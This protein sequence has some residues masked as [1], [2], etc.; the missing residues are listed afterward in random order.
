MDRFRGF[1]PTSVMDSPPGKVSTAL[2]K[3][4][5]V[6]VT[7]FVVTGVVPPS[8]V[9]PVTSSW[10]LVVPSPE[11]V[12]SKAWTVSAPEPSASTTLSRPPPRM[13]FSIS[14][15]LAVEMPSLIVP[16]SGFDA[17]RSTVTPVVVA[18]RSRV[19]P[20]V[21]PVLQ[22]SIVSLPKPSSITT[23]SSPDPP[24]MLSAPVPPIRMSSPAPALRLSSPAPPSSVS[25]LR[26]LPP[27][28]VSLPSCPSRLSAPSPPSI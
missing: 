28:S 21:S 6:T 11:S 16:A 3:A 14:V 22:P 26:S 10:S 17:L 24:N 1:T 18:L 15:K 9:S 25:V 7:S 20:S 8:E 5:A 4:S 2:P 27:R 23:V 13:M 19:S 12:M